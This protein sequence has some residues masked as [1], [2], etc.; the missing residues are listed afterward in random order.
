MQCYS[1]TFQ[2]V[3]VTEVL[4]DA[5]QMVE[6]SVIF[7][8]P[9]HLITKS[10]RSLLSGLRISLLHTREQLGPERDEFAL[11]EASMAKK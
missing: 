7:N 2:Y 5:E 10:A 1:V 4:S 11:L 8:G 9:D 3:A 6:N